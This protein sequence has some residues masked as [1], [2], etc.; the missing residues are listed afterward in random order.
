MTKNSKI[1]L[2]IINESTSHL[3][4][5]GVYKTVIDSGY[6]MSLATV[7]NSLLAL[8][9]SGDIKRIPMEIGSDRYDKVLRHDHLICLKCGKVLDIM[10]DDLT[11]YFEKNVG[12]S[13][14]SYDLRLNY[15]C[16]EC[17]KKD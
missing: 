8:V 6:K 1:I 15:L 14:K 11:S 2:N 3:T 16:E 9:S 10:C 13:I 5:D 17:K 7:Y 12:V 4:A